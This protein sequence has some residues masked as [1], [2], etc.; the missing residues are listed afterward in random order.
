[1][2]EEGITA[3]LKSQLQSSSRAGKSLVDAEKS[4]AQTYQAASGTKYHTAKPSYVHLAK[5]DQ[6]ERKKPIEEVKYSSHGRKRSLFFKEHSV[7]KTM[8]SID[9]LEQD[10]PVDKS[11]LMSLKVPPQ[12]IGSMTS[13]HG[14][15]AQKQIVSL[16]PS[17]AVSKKTIA[18]IENSPKVAK[19]EFL[20]YSSQDMKSRVN[21]TRQPSINIPNRKLSKSSRTLKIPEVTADDLG[22][23][24]QKRYNQGAKLSREPS[25]N[26]HPTI[27]KGE[28]THV[29]E[30]EVLQFSKVKQ[31]AVKSINNKESTAVGTT[32]RPVICIKRPSIRSDLSKPSQDI[33]SNKDIFA[34]TQATQPTK[35]EPSISSFRLHK[36][37][38]VHRTTFSSTFVNPDTQDRQEL[39]TPLRKSPELSSKREKLM[40]QRP[41]KKRGHGRYQ[42]DIADMKGK[43]DDFFRTSDFKSIYND[44]P[45]RLLKMHHKLIV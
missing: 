34:R 1:M 10:M 5:N 35:Q 11:K 4:K 16:E 7:A 25:I 8:R 13:F 22:L 38:G 42:S 12:N 15:S 26:E 19:Q 41:A 20:E 32:F 9:S 33:E 36:K 14:T 17:L 43:M 6:T 45:F 40:T 18:N 37:P 28:P 44:D 29:K 30:D 2:I 3:R 27:S 39:S 21:I 23:L 31:D 24:S